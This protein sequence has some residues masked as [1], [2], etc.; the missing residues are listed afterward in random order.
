MERDGAALF[1]RIELDGRDED[2]MEGDDEAAEPLR[3]WENYCPNSDFTKT[4]FGKSF[5]AF[6]EDVESQESLRSSSADSDA[7]VGE[8]DDEGTDSPQKSA[9]TE[10]NAQTENLDPA[11]KKEVIC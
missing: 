8:I 9:S 7:D 6:G 5:A 11:T 10:D 2:S 1:K 4:K 3:V